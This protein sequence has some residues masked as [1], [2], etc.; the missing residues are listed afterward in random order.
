MC[1]MDMQVESRSETQER[2]MV[3]RQLIREGTASTQE[4]LCKALRQKGYDV[5]QSTVSRD[6][7]RINAI[8][9]TNSEGEVIYRLPEHHVMHAHVTH[10]LNGLLTDIQN[11]E[12]MIVLHTTPGS[13]SLVAR[14]IDSMRSGLGILGTIAGDDTIFIVPAAGKRVSSVIRKVKEEF[15]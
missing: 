8:K 7:R 12:N 13:A 1:C 11:N 4:E 9:A 10:S 14:H 3:L 5:T 15:Y 6:L 2:Q